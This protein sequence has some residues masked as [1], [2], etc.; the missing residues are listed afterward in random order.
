MKRLQFEDFS[1]NVPESWKECSK[2]KIVKA[3]PIQLSLQQSGN[4]ADTAFHYL[5]ELAEILT[6]VDPAELNALDR[7]KLYAA[8]NWAVTAK[9]AHKPFEYFNSGGTTYYLPEEGFYNTS[10]LELA[11]ANIWYLLYTNPKKPQWTAVYQ[12]IATICRPRRLNYLVRK[13]QA[14]YNGDDRV[15]FNSVKADL[16]AKKF[17]DGLPLGVVMAILQYWES[18]NNAFVEQHK[19][20]FEG[21]GEGANL[22]ANGEGW[23]AMLED[24]AKENVHGDFDKVSDTNCH[25]VWMYMKHRKLVFDEQAR[26]A[27]KNET[28]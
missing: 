5:A 3:L 13:M 22:F 1:I 17:K 19:A 18:S 20:L 15:I 26:V 9:V 21:S 7:M 12:L 6:G 11:M 23:I 16:A 8:I 2:H 27:R 25:T 4:D 28:E 10:S 14:N 24:V